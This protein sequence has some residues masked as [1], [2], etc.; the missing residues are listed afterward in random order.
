MAAKGR[1]GSSAI[2]TR[3][4]KPKPK[5]I[6]KGRVVRPRKQGKAIPLADSA[7]ISPSPIKSCEHLDFDRLPKGAPSSGFSTPKARK[8]RIP[9]I[10]TCPPAPKKQ[11]V[12][13]PD[14]SLTRRQITF[15]APPDL[16]V[17]FMFALGNMSD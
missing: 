6:S 16:E 15:F 8:Y 14:Q 12:D 2:R 3:S 13:V 17:F 11:R 5:T 1:K 9:K 10:K 7:S 4:A